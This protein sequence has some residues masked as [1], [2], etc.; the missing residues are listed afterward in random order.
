MLQMI[1]IWMLLVSAHRIC[2]H[3]YGTRCLC[4]PQLQPPILPHRPCPPPVPCPPLPP[5]CPP[6]PALPHVYPSYSTPGLLS[7][8]LQGR[9]NGYAP[10]Q[11]Y[12][13][14]LREKELS[15]LEK[16]IKTI[17]VADEKAHVSPFDTV[18]VTP[19]KSVET[20]PRTRIVPS[21]VPH[22]YTPLPESPA[23]PPNHLGSI[24]LPPSLPNGCIPGYAIASQVQPPSYHIPIL[25][26]ATQQHQFPSHL[27]VHFQ[28]A[29]FQ[30][31]KE[32]PESSKRKI[33]K[34]AEEVFSGDFHVV[35]SS[36]DFTY[37]A[38]SS[39]FCQA[40]NGNLSCYAFQTGSIH[41]NLAED[42]IE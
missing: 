4:P 38:R 29:S 28:I 8:P 30:A 13:Y 10:P 5:S 41:N 25:Q 3:Y 40:K 35:C 1:F 37:I 12:S 18:D 15:N 21:H 39:L 31:I 16:Q 20:A 14:S 7:P 33:Q 6:T 2:A 24:S 9:N 23:Y 26:P 32:N 11:P 17:E 22:I 27:E 34:L 19:V 36:E 42:N